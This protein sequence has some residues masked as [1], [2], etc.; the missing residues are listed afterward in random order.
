MAKYIIE[1]L[2]AEVYEWCLI[3]YGHISEIVG[4]D[5]L[6]FTNIKGDDF[7]K[8]KKLGSVFEKNVSELKFQDICVLSQ[9]SKTALTAGDKSKFK[10]F[11]FGGIL[12]DNPAKKRTDWI[13]D[14]LRE[15]KISFGKRSLGNVQMPTDNAVYA[16]KKILDGSKLSGLKFI[17]EVEIEVNENESVVLPFRYVVDNNRL[18]ISEKLVEHLR[19]RKEF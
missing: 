11:V 15:A 9:Y 12:G 17:D 19:N 1:H 5:N 6:I 10:Y 2:E 3:E 14:E 16:A 4:K 8:L 7:K 18:V 13:I